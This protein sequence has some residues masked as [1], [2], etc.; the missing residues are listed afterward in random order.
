MRGREVL[1]LREHVTQVEHMI[2]TIPSWEYL[3]DETGDRWG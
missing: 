1:E 3:P 2:D